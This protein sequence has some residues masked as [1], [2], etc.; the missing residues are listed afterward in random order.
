MNL[1]KFIANRDKTDS[2]KLAYNLLQLFSYG[3]LTTYNK[4]KGNYPALT[5]KMRRKLQKLTLISIAEENKKIPFVQI[6]K[7][8]ELKNDDE[9]EELVLEIL[10]ANLLEAEISHSQGILF[11]RWC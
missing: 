9:V 3:T 8:L 6:Q 4:N 10:T 7:E 1:P 5:D 2:G 11:I